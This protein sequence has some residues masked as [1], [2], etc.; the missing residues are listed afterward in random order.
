MRQRHEPGQIS[1]PTG[2]FGTVSPG[3]LSQ[4]EGWPR[5][6]KSPDF[7]ADADKAMLELL[8]ETPLLILL[9]LGFLL[10]TAVLG[11]LAYH[12]HYQVDIHERARQARGMRNEYIE[13]VAARRE[14]LRKRTLIG[15]VP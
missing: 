7:P 10:V 14:E 12:L 13:K 15:R 8:F 1:G 2:G 6:L 5:A 11:T 3:D 9:G 4:F